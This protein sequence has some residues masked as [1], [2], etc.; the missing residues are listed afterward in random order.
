MHSKS[1]AGKIFKLDFTKPHY[2]VVAILIVIFGPSLSYAVNLISYLHTVLSV[3]TILNF[4]S[5][6]LQTVYACG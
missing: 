3:M 1:P 6:L 4:V 5:K 2:V